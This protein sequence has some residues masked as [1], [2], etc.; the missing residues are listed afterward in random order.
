M[1]AEIQAAMAP[2]ANADEVTCCCFCRPCDGRADFCQDDVMAEIKAAAAAE[3]AARKQVPRAA[4]LLIDA[5]GFVLFT[6]LI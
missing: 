4:F 3:E 2:Q 6:H 1:I 5:Q